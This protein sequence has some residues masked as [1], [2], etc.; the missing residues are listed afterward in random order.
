MSIK[1]DGM[2]DALSHFV[3]TYMCRFKSMRWDWR[4]TNKCQAEIVLVPKNAESVWR[5]PVVGDDEGGFDGIL[6]IEKREGDVD[7]G[8]DTLYEYLWGA[9]LEEN[10]SHAP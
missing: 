3:S 6:M 4:D 1:F 9:S 7:L 10:S 5:V 2:A 8:I